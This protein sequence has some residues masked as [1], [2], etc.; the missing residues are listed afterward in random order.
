MMNEPARVGGAGALWAVVWL[1]GCAS[2]LEPRP[3]DSSEAS[4]ATCAGAD[5][6]ADS[7]AATDPT[8]Y[9]AR[10]EVLAAE[11]KRKADAF[12]ARLARL[13]AERE[14]R[15]EARIAEAQQQG[16]AKNRAALSAL[17][18]SSRLQRAAR[19]A[20]P[21]A[22]PERARLDP[23]PVPKSRPVERAREGVEATR[24]T[25]KVVDPSPDGL[26]VAAWCVLGDES[27]A[28]ERRMSA[29]RREGAPRRR[30]GAWALAV[31]DVRGLEADAAAEL[32]TRGLAKRDH[33]CP[34]PSGAMRRLVRA[35]YGPG[36]VGGEPPAALSRG[37]ERLRRELEETAGLPAPE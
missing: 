5:C 20:K 12:R 3:P 21:P 33:V 8:R 18:S 14:A 32:A 31:V 7:A 15:E 2:S 36:A 6:P 30:V 4:G 16:A 17:T 19:D 13:R 10:E 26:L 34:K 23:P 22:A 1:A 24:E 27:E 11:A 28:A 25:S 35:L 37:A 9:E 29:L